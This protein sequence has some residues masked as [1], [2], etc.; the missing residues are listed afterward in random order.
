MSEIYYSEKNKYRKPKD[1]K[2]KII[3]FLKFYLTP[4][5]RDPEF[6]HIEN[7]IYKIKTRRKRFRR[8]LTPL[9][10]I[11]I[12]I[13][14]FIIILG[15]Y[16]PW[17]SSYTI[18]SLSPPYYPPDSV[19]FSPPSLEHPLG[20]TKYGYDVL[21]RIIWGARTAITA[22]IIPVFIGIG[23]G[24]RIGLISGYY[25]GKLDYVVMRVVDIMYALPT[26][27]LMIIIAPLVRRDLY[28]ILIIYGFLSVPRFTRFMRSIVL[29][30]QEMSYVKAAKVGGANKLKI[31]MKHLLPN[32]VSPMII[33]FFNLMA[34]SIIGVAGLAFLG[35]IE[36]KEYASWGSDI[37]W[38][39]TR[40]SAYWAV[41]FPGLILGITV[42]GLLF[43][44]DGMRDAFDP[45]LHKKE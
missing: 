43:I 36:V 1:L 19:P 26:L 32:S 44:G 30:V 7:E 16:A 21:G 13:Y 4:G 29:Q 35:L 14:V 11:G 25:G 34:R 39:R 3:R 27:V 17:I 10:M 22:G 5:W 2:T 45:R 42:M 24:I 18:Q 6:T 8:V 28:L 41:V 37:I 20:T 40:F 15:V 33:A 12:A 38:A 31:M 9:T 23:L